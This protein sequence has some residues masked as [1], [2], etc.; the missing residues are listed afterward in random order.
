MDRTYI[1][2][3]IDGLNNKVKVLEQINA[4]NAE[5]Y[6]LIKAE[7]F[8]IEAF[9]KNSNEKG[10]LIYQLNKLDDGFK[11]V[12][13]DIKDEL[14][15]NKLKYATEIKAMQELIVRIT[16]LSTKIQADEARN[17]A[18]LEN[19]FKIERSKL[20]GTRSQAKAASSYAKMMR[21]GRDQL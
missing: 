21:S 18:A 3:L 15:Q 10:V 8:S 13:D 19:Y 9:D 20:K 16:D 4:K 5:Q 2:A 17:K 7:S 14:A 6:E 12:Y 11:M 1:V